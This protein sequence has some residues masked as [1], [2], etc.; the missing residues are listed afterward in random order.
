MSYAKLFQFYAIYFS[1]FL[2]IIFIAG[3]C[4]VFSFARRQ[5]IYNVLNVQIHERQDGL[6]IL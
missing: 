6:L 5:H 1:V 2:K 3:A 4:T